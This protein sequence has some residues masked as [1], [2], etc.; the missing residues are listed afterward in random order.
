MGEKQSDP[1]HSTNHG[2]GLQQRCK[3]L[4]IECL[5]I[6]PGSPEIKHN[7]ATEYL[8]KTLTKGD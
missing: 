6:Y 4:G 7:T 3:E 1:T 8:I 5:L 2:L